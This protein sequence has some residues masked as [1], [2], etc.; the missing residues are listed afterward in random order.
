MKKH[1]LFCLLLSIIFSFGLLSSTAFA[2]SASSPS[3]NSNSITF[4]ASEY[5]TGNPISKSFTSEI[6]GKTVTNT[7]TMT[8]LNDVEVPDSFYPDSIPPIGSWYTYD[9]Y[10]HDGLT[11]CGRT[12]VTVFIGHTD[13]K[14]TYFG[15]M[16]SIQIIATYNGYQP[17]AVSQTRVD[18]WNFFTRNY[19]SKNGSI[20]GMNLYFNINSSTGNVTIDMWYNP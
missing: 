20:G 13:D 7:I 1:Y 6:N 15:T 8:K 9:Y 14:G 19:F 10:A 11:Q 3:D 17:Y 18:W 4:T 5:E 12:R 2:V 16:Q